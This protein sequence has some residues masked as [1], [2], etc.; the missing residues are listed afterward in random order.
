PRFITRKIRTKRDPI[1]KYMA[2]VVDFGEHSNN[3]IQRT[4]LPRTESSYKET[5][6]IFNKAF[7]EWVVKGKD[8]RIEERPTVG[9]IKGFFSISNLLS[10]L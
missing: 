3:E 4:V 9:T 10:R 7:L 1:L 2:N 5:L 6:L 8:G